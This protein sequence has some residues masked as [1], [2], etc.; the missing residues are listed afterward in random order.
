M[1]KVAIL[2]V[3]YGPYHLE[4][5]N[6][7][8]KQCSVLGW[9]A[10]GIELTRS[11]VAY[12]WK[13]QPEKFPF[14]I[15][16]VLGEKE[17]GEVSFAYLQE[18]LY[19][20]LSDVNPDAIAIA[21]YFRLSMIAALGWSVWK[22]KPAIL[23]SESKEDD[24][25]RNWFKETF[26]FWLFKAYKAALVG[27][28]VHKRY[29]TKLGMPSSAIFF[30]YN[31]VGNKVL[32]PNKIKSLK[33]PLRKPYFLAINRFIPKKNLPFVVEAYGMYRQ[34]M[35]DNAWDLVLC[36]D[37][38]MRLQIEQQINE[39]GLSNF[40]HIPGFLQQDQLLPYF[41]HANCFIHA[42]T[43]EQWGLVV[44]E[45]MAAGLPVLVS[46]RCGCFEDLVV[47]PINGFGFC[48]YDRQQ[49]IDLMLKISSGEVNL[50]NMS[51]AALQHIEKFSPEYFAQGLV[52]A[53]K[54]ALT[55]N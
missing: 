34:V 32:H 16:S 35:G 8:Q 25:S 43:H 21:G 6:G 42:S 24:G 7:F 46:N 55:Y 4:R 22:R 23:L 37:G 36:G 3:N 41:A 48:P 38:Q 26:K 11:G 51:Q 12:D 14:S 44:N 29:L 54:Y 40:I 18:K 33:I 19:A 15:I 31:V 30:G 50:K 53:V 52:G 17:L 5:L 13:T 47:E 27:G 28:E 20:V 39:S 2:F 10:I 9:S 1:T 45:A 49:L